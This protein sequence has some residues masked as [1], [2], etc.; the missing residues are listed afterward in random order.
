MADNRL[1][2]ALDVPTRA[3][4]DA[5]VA[6]LGDSVSY[7]KVGMEFFYSEGGAIVRDLRAQGK[8]VFLDLKLHDIPNTVAH[9]LGALARLGASMFNV[10]ASGGYAMMKAA[11]EHL[12]AEADKAGAPRP[13][14]IAVTVLTSMGADD[15]QK[16]GMTAPVESQVVRL[17]QLAQ[18]AGLDGVVASP[19]EAAA[20]RAACGEDFLIVTPGVRPAWA[21]VND[22][23]R[24]AAP[25]DA[26][27]SGA[28]H[29]VVGRPITAAA[30]PRA[31]AL[32]ILEEM[33]AQ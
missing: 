17:A 2:V 29:L 11:K 3:R 18:S 30:D 16:L 12:D 25:K 24:I 6:A 26:L 20:I 5:L 8:E 4:A 15:W 32:R 31:A 13:Q 7:Y 9:G 10:H 1:I 27:S 14:L 23:S 28:T 22:Q 21:A 19:R 33:G